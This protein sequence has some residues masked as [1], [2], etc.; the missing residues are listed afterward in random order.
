MFDYVQKLQLALTDTARRTT[1]KVVAGV[2]FAAGAAFLLAALWSFLAHDLGWGSMKAS[3]TIGAGFV[4]IAL[5]R[6]LI[7]NRRRHVMPTTDELRLEVEARA[8]ALADAAVQRA[9]DEAS[10]VVDMAGNK[11]HSL[12]DDAGYR[13]NKL[14]NDA[15]RR[16]VQAAHSVG[17]TSNNI[18]AAKAKLHDAGD[19]ISRASNSNAGSMAKLVGAFAVGVTVASKLAESRKQSRYD[20][21]DED[22]YV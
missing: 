6:R 4:A 11:V 17:L 15:E 9:R 19:T 1:M 22:D 10:R 18:D 20:D 3:L 12:M 13:A 5:I 8:S 16:V 7:S 14:A 21:Y 2:V